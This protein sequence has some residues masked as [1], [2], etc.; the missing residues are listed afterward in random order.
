MLTGLGPSGRE[1]VGD[2][3]L[4]VGLVRDPHGHGPVAAILILPQEAQALLGCSLPCRQD[5]PQ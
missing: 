1:E 4:V 5:L 3:A 2:P